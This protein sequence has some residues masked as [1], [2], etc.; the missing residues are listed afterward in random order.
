MQTTLSVNTRMENTLWL[1]G[2]VSLAVVVTIA[3]E[4]VFRGVH[5]ASDLKEGIES[6]LQTVETV[7][8]SAAKDRPLQDEWQKRLAL[9]STV[10]TSRLNRLHPSIQI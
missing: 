6:R 8:S 2:V 10:G 4:Y 5:P 1:A 3:V 9:Y 7:L